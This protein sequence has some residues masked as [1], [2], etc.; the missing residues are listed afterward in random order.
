MTTEFPTRRAAVHEQVIDGFGTVRIIPL[1]P[2]VDIDVI[3]EWVTQERARF[4]G[5]LDADRE[6]VLEVYGFLDTLTTHHA[7]LVH[8]DDRPV[9]LF[10]TYEPEFDPVGECYEVQPGDFGIHLMI[11]PVAGG[12][13]PGFTGTL[14]SVFLGHVL[15]EP[16]RKR[17]VAE[18]DA[19]N[20]KAIARLLRTG[21]VL[22]P[23]IDLPEKR[24]RLVF[25]DRADFGAGG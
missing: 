11:G 8:R 13:E 2:P 3:Y 12:P 25:L 18:P 23:E 19:R 5:M 17:I 10:Q 15:A 6:R 14:L 7:Y 21:F 24:A 9:A 16:G 20:D 4:W 1:D 22:G